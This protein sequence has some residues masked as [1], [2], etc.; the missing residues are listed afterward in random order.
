VPAPRTAGP[1]EIFR[2]FLLVGATSFG[3]GVMAH[4]RT[5][6]VVTHRWLDDEAFLEL[7]AISQTLP[8]LK[9]THIAILAGDRLCGARGA[10]AAMLGLCLPGAL[11]MYAVGAAYQA[12]RD[13]PLVEAALRGVAPAAVGLIL[14]TTLELGR[15]TLSRAADIVF[16]VMTV[17]A[18]N[19]LHLSVPIVLIG[20]GALAVAWYSR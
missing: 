9:A 17:V 14:V 12:E 13:R 20:V 3:G 16:V 15:K 10:I 8:G 18:V 19:R 5:C 1:G 4:L 2:A 6:L 7:L 11:A